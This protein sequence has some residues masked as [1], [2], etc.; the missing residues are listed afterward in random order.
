MAHTEGM[1]HAV[2]HGGPADGG[3]LVLVEPVPSTL[4]FPMTAVRA[5]VV[6][7]RPQPP[8]SGSFGGSAWINTT[9]AGAYRLDATPEGRVIRD[10]RRRIVY[11]YTPA[12]RPAATNPTE[13]EPH[14]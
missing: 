6:L 5:A 7:V 12:A 3:E 1:M 8:A 13:G 11:R 14:E 10:G 2:F 9:A 4:T